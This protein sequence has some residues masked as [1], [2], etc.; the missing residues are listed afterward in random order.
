MMMLLAT[1]K[2]KRKKIFEKRLL[3]LLLSFDVFLNDLFTKTKATSLTL[4]FL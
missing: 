4:Y 3:V 1:D 2:N